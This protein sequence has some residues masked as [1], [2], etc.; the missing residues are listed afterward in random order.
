MGHLQSSEA[1][2]PIDVKEV[3]TSG[4]RRKSDE[5]FLWVE[6]KTSRKLVYTHF[7]VYSSDVSRS[8]SQQSVFSR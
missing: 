8:C 4:S 5:K 7:G 1:L 2:T 3:L 6:V